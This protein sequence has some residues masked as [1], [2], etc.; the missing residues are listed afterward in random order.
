MIMVSIE[1]W[2]NL[3]R[4][5]ET[6]LTDEEWDFEALSEEI[7]E[8]DKFLLYKESFSKIACLLIYKYLIIRINV[9]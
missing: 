9:I 1:E 5:K 7:Y 3:L 8:D 2:K 6:P 4:R